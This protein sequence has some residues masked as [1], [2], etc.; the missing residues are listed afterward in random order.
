VS[1]RA[2]IWGPTGKGSLQKEGSQNLGTLGSERD[3][4]GDRSSKDDPLGLVIVMDTGSEWVNVIEEE[5]GLR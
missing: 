5:Y 3:P 4:L 1:P 2:E